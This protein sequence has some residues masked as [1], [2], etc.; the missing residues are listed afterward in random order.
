MPKFAKRFFRYYYLKLVRQPGSPDYIARGVAI[1]LFIG[2]LIPM[3]GQ[4]VVALALAYLLKAHKIPAMGC[5]WIT[6][7]FTIGFIYP[8]QCYL[9]SYFTKHPLTLEELKVIFEQFID[10]V[11]KA[12]EQGFVD[13]IQLAFKELLKLGS[14]IL[15]PFFIGGAIIGGILALIGYFTAYGVITHHRAK[16][17]IRLNKKLAKKNKEFAE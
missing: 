5:T 8:I 12:E 16:K 6:N 4:I 13:G 11:I 7:H 15:V 3:G 17:D 1:G 14:E 10:A 9:G 2:M